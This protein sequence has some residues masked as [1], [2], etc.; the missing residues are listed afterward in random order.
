MKFEETLKRSD[1]SNLC[2]ITKQQEFELYLGPFTNYAMLYG[3]RALTE[4]YDS[5]NFENFL[6]YFDVQLRRKFLICKFGFME[7]N[8]QKGN[9]MVKGVA[10]T[11]AAFS[12]DMN[13]M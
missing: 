11:Y 4:A 10:D 5:Y 2:S 6:T 9:R 1:F 7:G 8:L 12:I 13:I 3:G